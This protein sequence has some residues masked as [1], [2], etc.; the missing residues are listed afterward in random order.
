MNIS[1]QFLVVGLFDSLNVWT[2]LIQEQFYQPSVT[3]R[4]NQRKCCLKINQY[5]AYILSYLQIGSKDS[6]THFIICIFCK[7]YLKILSTR[8]TTKVHWKKHGDPSCFNV[9]TNQVYS[10][11]ARRHVMSDARQHQYWRTTLCGMVAYC[12]CSAHQLRFEIGLSFSLS[13]VRAWSTYRMKRARA[14][15]TLWDR[16]DNFVYFGAK[17]SFFQSDPAFCDSFLTSYQLKSGNR[18]VVSSVKFSLW[19]LSSESFHHLFG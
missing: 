5:L 2:I 16:E 10:D 18:P 3:K 4:L 17:R 12:Y 11:F 1:I 15:E 8:N 19:F 14:P 13:N 6:S 9:L 7:G